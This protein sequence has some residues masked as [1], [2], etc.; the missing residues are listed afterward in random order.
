M[1]AIDI[2]VR[3]PLITAFHSCF[4]ANSPIENSWDFPSPLWCRGHDGFSGYQIEWH[5]IRGLEKPPWAFVIHSIPQKC[6]CSDRH[7]NNSGAFEQT[8]HVLPLAR[9]ITVV[10]L[11]LSPII[12]LFKAVENWLV[13]KLHTSAKSDE[14]KVNFNAIAVTPLVLY[15]HP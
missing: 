2:V 4:V 15:H 9:Q 10:R 12:R 14:A 8:L 6:H 7:C 1:A 13:V 3:R 11:L 5:S